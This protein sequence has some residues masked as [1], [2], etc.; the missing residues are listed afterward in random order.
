MSII[1]RLQCIYEQQHT[2]EEGGEFTSY[3]E[4]NVGLSAPVLSPSSFLCSG[5]NCHHSQNSTN[6]IDDPILIKKTN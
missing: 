2:D 5:V 4:S 3:T 6:E 1:T